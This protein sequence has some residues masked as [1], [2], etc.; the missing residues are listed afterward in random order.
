MVF[1]NFFSILT[2][3]FPQ[4][5]FFRDLCEQAKERCESVLGIVGLQWPEDTDCSQF[6]EENSGNQTC[7]TPDEDVEGYLFLKTLK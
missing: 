1:G 3:F 4:I 2:P 5:N 6:P 7:L